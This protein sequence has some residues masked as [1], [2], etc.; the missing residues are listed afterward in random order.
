MIDQLY[1]GGPDKRIYGYQLNAS[2]VHCSRPNAYDV[3]K[4]PTAVLHMMTAH[5]YNPR[6]PLD[7]PKHAMRYTKCAL[8]HVY[9]HCPPQ[10]RLVEDEETGNCGASLRLTNHCVA[11]VTRLLNSSAAPQDDSLD[12]LHSMMHSASVG[13]KQKRC[14]VR[15]WHP[16][17]HWYTAF[18][19]WLVF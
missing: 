17:T 2:F 16:S 13:F 1:S 4:L 5:R 14:R 18:I 7:C 6:E 9:L 19:N 10:H 15:R 11:I 3:A 8:A 12:R